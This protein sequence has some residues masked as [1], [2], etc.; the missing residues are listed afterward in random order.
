M[1]GCCSSGLPRRSV[2]EG[3]EAFAVCV[4]GLKR[5]TL[6]SRRRQHAD[7][8]SYKITWCTP[9]LLSAS[10]PCV[11]FC[12]MR[13]TLF[14]VALIS[15]VL[16]AQAVPASPPQFA[17]APPATGP[18]SKISCKTPENASMCYW[19]RGR[20]TCCN[21][22]PAMRIWEVGTKRILGI[23]SGP[24]SWMLDPEDNEHPKLPRNIDLA[25]RAESRRTGESTAVPRL[26]G[27][28]FGDFEICQL[29]PEHPGW[30][31]AVCIELA[32]NIFFDRTKHG[33]SWETTP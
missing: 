11:S 7:D 14:A 1:R 3:P 18:Q 16:G 27:P 4:A 24:N 23:Y 9:Q 19:T 10:A 5:K 33:Y 28:L 6:R 22:N 13:G 2:S 32:K 15:L 8:L 31:Q 25:Y 26:T 29:E 30:M 12:G 17:T 20:L 21:G